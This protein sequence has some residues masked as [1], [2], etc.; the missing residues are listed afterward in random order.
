MCMYMYV[1]VLHMSLVLC[2][3][4]HMYIHTKNM[5]LCTSFFI[6]LQVVKRK[7]L[8]VLLHQWALE[9]LTNQKLEI[10]VGTLGILHSLKRER[11]RER[12][13]NF[14]IPSCLVIELPQQP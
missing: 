8:L 10:S 5:R 7:P 14:Q 2:S 11:E 6:F 4:I 9:L 1:H 12:D 3:I 13:H